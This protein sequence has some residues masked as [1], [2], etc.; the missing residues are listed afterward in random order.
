MTPS[1]FDM[2]VSGRLSLAALLS[3][4]PFLSVFQGNQRT[5]ARQGLIDQFEFDDLSLMS[6]EKKQEAKTKK[7]P[8]C[9]GSRVCSAYKGEADRRCNKGQIERLIES[10]GKKNWYSH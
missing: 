6:S 5:M 10:W 2:Y 4:L 7:C 9:D 8:E 1:L 3:L